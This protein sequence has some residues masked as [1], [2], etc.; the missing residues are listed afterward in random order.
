VDRDG[1]IG[2]DDEDFLKHARS[3]LNDAIQNQPPKAAT[4]PKAHPS[5]VKVNTSSNVSTTMMKR[6]MPILVLEEVKFVPLHNATTKN[7][8]SDAV[9][10]QVVA[11][12]VSQTVNATV[13]ANSNATEVKDAANTTKRE[14]E[15]PISPKMTGISHMFHNMFAG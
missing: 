1:V 15:R 2:E 8:S 5:D 3:L 7:D 4:M 12:S 13:P 14:E 6:S 10:D 11:R 9:H